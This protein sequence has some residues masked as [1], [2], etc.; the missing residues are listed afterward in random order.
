MGMML[1]KS[2]PARTVNMS[3]IRTAPALQRHSP[4]AIRTLISNHSASMPSSDGNGGLDPRCTLCG[5]KTA[6]TLRIPGSF[7]PAATPRGF[8]AQSR[9]TF[10]WFAWRIGLRE[11]ISSRE[12]DIRLPQM[13]SGGIGNSRID[14]NN[15]RT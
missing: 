8:S 9:M 4:S 1:G 11:G 3:W 5:P 13:L 6:K 15:Y 2:L 7:P 10:F 14:F 12:R